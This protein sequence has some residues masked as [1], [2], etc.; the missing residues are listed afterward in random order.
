VGH[1]AGGC[2]EVKEDSLFIRCPE[3]GAEHVGG[4]LPSLVMWP[5]S[6]PTPVL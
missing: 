3:P 5:G 4:E 6:R 1:R 2:A